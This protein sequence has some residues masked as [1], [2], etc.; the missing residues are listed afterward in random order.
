VL[1]FPD[2]EVPDLVY[3][4]NGDQDSI[5]RD[6]QA[7]IQKYAQRF[8]KLLELAAPAEEFVTRIEA[9]ARDRF[10]GF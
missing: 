2:P 7:E 8:G 5:W 4:E 1:E 6:E 3:L 10:G 9:V